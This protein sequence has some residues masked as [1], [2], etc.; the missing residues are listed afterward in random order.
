M[1]ARGS[2]SRAQG[3]NLHFF[4]P[5]EHCQNSVPDFYSAATGKTAPYLATQ[6]AP[7]WAIYQEAAVF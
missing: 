7:S 4:L 2:D 6:G 3:L 1:L 5:Q